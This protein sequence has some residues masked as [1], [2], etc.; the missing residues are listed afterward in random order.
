LSGDVGCLSSLPVVYGDLACILYTSGTTGVPKGV[1]VTRKSII[2]VAEFYVDKYD[3]NGS[4]VYGLFS[5]IGFDV[6][7]FIIGA[8]LYSGASLSVVPEDIRLNM[9]ELNEYF[10]NQGVTHSFITTQVGKLFM[11]SVEETSLNLLLV[12]GEKL[13]NFESPIDY[14]LVDG[15]GPTEAFAF[16][17]SI[18]NSEK[19]TGSSVGYLNYNTKAYILDYEC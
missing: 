1:K 11:E 19:I 13:G 18:L 9:V 4:D 14:E 2:N 10:I 16:M 6:S 12:A 8:V 5:A 7:N 15:F 3:L 17:S